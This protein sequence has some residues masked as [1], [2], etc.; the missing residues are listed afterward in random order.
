MSSD[1]LHCISSFQSNWTSLFCWQDRLSGSWDRFGFRGPIWSST[2]GPVWPEHS[3]A[4]APAPDKASGVF[5]P[6]CPNRTRHHRRHAHLS[7]VFQTSGSRYVFA[8]L[9]GTAWHHE[10]ED[11]CIYVRTA[12][13]G[14]QRPCYTWRSCRDVVPCFLRCGVVARDAGLSVEG[15]AFCFGDCCAIVLILALFVAFLRALLDP[16]L[17]LSHRCAGSGRRSACAV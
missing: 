8:P 10:A 6:Y 1:T 14:A 11:A 16:S 5:R 4:R 3:L 2:A 9:P 15:D 7:L 17:C 12:R 13:W